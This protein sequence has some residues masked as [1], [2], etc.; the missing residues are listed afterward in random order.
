[1]DSINLKNYK[2]KKKL[3]KSIQ[4]SIILWKINI[5]FHIL[6]YFDLIL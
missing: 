2:I 1:M 5:F 4:F 6:Y 3:K